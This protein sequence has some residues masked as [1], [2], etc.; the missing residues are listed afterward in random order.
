MR[1]C[2]STDLIVRFSPRPAQIGGSKRCRA[3]TARRRG[4]ADKAG[5]INASYVL[6]VLRLTLPAPATVEAIPDGRAAEAPT[7]AEAMRVTLKLHVS[8]FL[9]SDHGTPACRREACAG[10]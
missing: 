10:I 4:P 9:H 8:R 1:P 7:L 6:R 5:K 3:N 2:R